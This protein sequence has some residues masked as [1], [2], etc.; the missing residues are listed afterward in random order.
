MNE[1][2]GLLEVTGSI[3][4]ESVAFYN[5]RYQLYWQYGILNDNVLLLIVYIQFTIRVEDNGA[6]KL[7]HDVQAEITVQDQNDQPP[8]FVS[9]TQR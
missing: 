4:R 8:V 5:V 1:D 3:D 2:T 6:T 7:Y 9:N